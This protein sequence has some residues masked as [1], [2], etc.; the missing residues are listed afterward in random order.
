MDTER[1]RQLGERLGQVIFEASLARQRGEPRAAADLHGEA[2]TIFMAFERWNLA[3]AQAEQALALYEEAGDTQQAAKT[4]YA[5]S[6]IDARRGG[7]VGAAR[8]EPALEDQYQG[9]LTEGAHDMAAR[10]ADQLTGLA[11]RRQDLLGALRWAERCADA[12]ADA[13][14]VKQVLQALRTRTQILQLLGRPYDAYVTLSRAIEIGKQ[15]GG[16]ALSEAVLALRTDMLLLAQ[17]PVVAP[18]LKPES[19]DVLL[20]EAR[21]KGNLGLVAQLSLARGSERVQVRDFVRGEADAQVAREAALQVKDPTSYLIACLLLAEVYDKTNRRLEALTILFTC[22]A[23]LGDLLGQQ[24]RVPVWV[25]IDSLKDRWGVA[26]FE[27]EM[28]RY[29]G[30]FDGG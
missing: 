13:G 1:Y 2:V 22:Q 14:E 25:V 20:E 23:S 28:A 27:E 12:W 7:D 26:V 4:R 30:Q 15:L 6:I 18:G 19:A 11:M 5:L 17:N 16:D 29:R 10:A 21:A 24:A 8:A 9:F 3:R